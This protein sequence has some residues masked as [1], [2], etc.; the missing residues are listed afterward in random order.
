MRKNGGKSDEELKELRMA[1]GM[2]MRQFAA[3][4][5][6]PYRTYDKWERGERTPPPYVIKMLFKCEEQRK[7]ENAGHTDPKEQK[8][9]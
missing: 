3:L 2:T 4:Y 5:E 1:A 7:K 8:N 6:I 9:S